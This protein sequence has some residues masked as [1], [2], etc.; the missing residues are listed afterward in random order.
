METEP[1]KNR[2]FP[3]TPAERSARQASPL[4]PRELQ[5]AELVAEGLSNLEIARE[6]NLQEPTVKGHLQSARQKLGCRN[7]AQLAAWLHRRSS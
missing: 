6:L 3:D 2:Y 5:V 4:S 7:R 1:G